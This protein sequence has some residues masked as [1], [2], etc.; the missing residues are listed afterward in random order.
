MS[1]NKFSKE[2]SKGI[3]KCNCGCGLYIEKGESYI[4]FDGRGRYGN[5][6]LQCALNLV[7]EGTVNLSK[8]SGTTREALVNSMGIEDR[9]EAEQNKVLEHSTYA[10]A[11]ESFLGWHGILGYA[12][13][14]RSALDNLRTSCEKRW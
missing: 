14:I 9:S 7:G 13:T 2:V 6:R 3:R 4:R 12:T 5:L 11:F 1:D 8:V 10:E